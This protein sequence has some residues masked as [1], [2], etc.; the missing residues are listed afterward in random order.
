MSRWPDPGKS[1]DTTIDDALG[2]SDVV[3]LLSRLKHRE[4]NGKE[5]RAAALRRAE[6]ADPALN[7]LTAWIADERQ[8]ASQTGP[9]AGIPTVIKDNEE[10]TGLPTFMGSM[11]I[12][13][14]P[15]K[16]NAPFAAYM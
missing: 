15:A 1:I 16:A 4:V 8:D 13:S 12:Q 9:F 5:L 11:A 2:D 14:Q 10:L 3:D 6:L 7:A